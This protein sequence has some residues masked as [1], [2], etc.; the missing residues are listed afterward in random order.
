ME[1]GDVEEEKRAKMKR[2]IED[3]VFGS[4]FIREIVLINSIQFE[5]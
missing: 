4:M 1:D 5:S 3:E 2:M